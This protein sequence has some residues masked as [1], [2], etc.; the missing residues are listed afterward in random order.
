MTGLIWLALLTAANLSEGATSISRSDAEADI[1]QYFSTLQRVHPDLLA[2]VTVQDYLALMQQTRNEVLGKADT[3]GQARVEDLAYALYY[4]AAFFRDG[5]TSI[6]SCPLPTP[7]E[8]NIRFPGFLLS[9]SDGL[10][11]S[12]P[13]RNGKSSG[14][15]CWR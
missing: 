15:N 6:D 1:Q 4:A 10:L 3:N 11:S 9:Y 12:L 13:Q 2:K 5:H 7:D 8:S 14:W